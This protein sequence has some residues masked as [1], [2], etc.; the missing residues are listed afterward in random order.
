MSLH[1]GGKMANSKI[2]ICLDGTG[3]DPEDA[4]QESTKD[5]RLED[6][7]ISN[8]LKLHLLAGGK[9]NNAQDNAGQQTYYYSGVGTKGTVFRRTLA[10]I[11]AKLSITNPPMII[12]PSFI[13]V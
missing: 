10:S 2:I 9:L 3:N 1:K 6:D 13:I 12:Y 4:V 11:F 8:V 7:N 5:G